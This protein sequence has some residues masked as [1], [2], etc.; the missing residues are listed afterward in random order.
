M[1]LNALARCVCSASLLLLLSGPIEAGTISFGVSDLQGESSTK[2]T[3]LQFGPDGRLYVA[4]VD[5]L[6]H[7]YDVVRNGANN[8]AVT[9][10]E[11]I[12]AINLMPNR[13]DDGPLNP[14]VIGRHLTGLLVVGTPTD[15][16]IYVG[17]SDPR[18]GD[19]S[20]DSNSGVISKLM[21]STSGSWA[22][23][24]KI[25]LVNGLPRSRIDHS[26]N[27]LALSNDEST[28]YVCVAGNTNMGGAN[29]VFHFLPE[30]AYSAAILSVD[31]NAI[32]NSTYDL[33]T[34][35]DPSTARDTATPGVDLDDPFGGHGGFNMA[36][37][38]LGSP[39]QIHA[40]GF[41]N[42]YDVLIASD[43][44]MYT[45]DN[46][47]N[48]GEGGIPNNESPLGTCDL[49]VAN[50]DPGGTTEWDPLHW[51][52][53]ITPG[54]RYHGGHPNPTR[55]NPALLFSAAIPPGQFHPIECDYLQPITLAQITGGGVGEDN[56]IFGWPTSTNGLVEY[57]ASNFNGAMQGDLLAT[58]W[59][60]PFSVFRVKVTYDI[61]QV[62]TIVHDETLFQGIVGRP[63]DITTLG[64]G[65]P[66]PGTIWVS[67]FFG[68]GS[69]NS[70][71][72]YE[73]ND[74]FTCTGAYDG[75]DEDSDG[76][77]NADELDNGTNPCSAASVPADN[78][79]DLVSDI[80]DPD[81][82][83][84]TILDPSD[85]FAV[86]AQNG[87]TTF[88]PLEFTWD[89]VSHG[90]ILDLGFTG[91]MTNGVA[92]WTSQ[93]D[94]SKM[95]AGGAPGVITLDNV[96]AGDA[97]GATN[98]QEYAFQ[99]GVDVTSEVKPFTVETALKNF[100]LG[101]T[102]TTQSAGLFVGKGDQDNYLKVVA[103]GN[104]GAGG[105][106]VVLEIAGAPT[107]TM[108]PAAVLGNE[109]ALY[110]TVDPLALTVQPGYAIN[111]GPRIDVG[112][113]LAVPASWVTGSTALA[114]GMISTTGGGASYSATF[115]DLI[116]E[117]D[118]VCQP[119][120]GYGGPGTAVLSVCGQALEMGNSATLMLTGAPASAP[121]F[122]FIAI[123]ANPT[124]FPA[125]NGTLVPWPDDLLLT[126]STN[127]SGEL[128]FPVPGGPTPVSQI[129]I[130]V[131]L[132]D[133]SLP[134][135][136]AFSNAIRLEFLP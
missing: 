2:P 113:P 85:A 88:L 125:Y 135:G 16:V 131:A 123:A 55:A 42:P 93:F 3:S 103:A 4:D 33:P 115:N 39:V 30:F 120:L 100:L 86:D 8:Y 73:P 104:G 54:Q 116:I 49:L 58:G 121:A 11:T 108:F 18:I 17:S 68:N 129:H 101:K 136:A 91:L 35:D 71:Q 94:D 75:S 38:E 43:G 13:D 87:L 56:S 90:G 32:G 19:A 69:G 28:L 95:T 60:L 66:F 111:G 114:A 23:P 84:D 41:R 44:K 45:V 53:E 122:M 112:A 97:L 27:G 14:S 62:P 70:I 12:T 130:Q 81:D 67:V 92:T 128:T 51:V 106:E 89:S 7:V 126:F 31:L 24:I 132:P 98:T 59:N 40:T 34:L 117:S 50:P 82:D 21:Q 29:S 52:R 102:V 61:N 63:L 78:D 124:F 9:N 72:V 15:P 134:F 110:L 47:P 77:T 64:D 22:S 65:T 99:V 48:A 74:F 37:I 57:T 1:T 80:N 118:Y 96:T 105:I 46:S 36:T 76:Y 107:A 133:G 79:G 127:A 26:V 83:D 20:L 6:I 109:I 5:G 25:D 10:I 119:D